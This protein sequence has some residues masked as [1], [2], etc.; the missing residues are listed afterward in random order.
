MSKS[1]LAMGLVLVAVALVV[2]GALNF[3]FDAG[4]KKALLSVALAGAC[5]TAAAYI[6]GRLPART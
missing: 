5:T 4:N 3:G 6:W 2:Y 1:Q